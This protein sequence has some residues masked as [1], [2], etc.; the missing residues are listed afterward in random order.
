M[1]TSLQ[2]SRLSSEGEEKGMSDEEEL[3]RIG[4]ALVGSEG[5]GETLVDLEPDMR[6]LG[7]LET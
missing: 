1:M 4:Q 5:I 3:R 2:T 6:E 7:L